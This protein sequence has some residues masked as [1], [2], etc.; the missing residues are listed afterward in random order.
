M[1]CVGMVTQGGAR[2][3]GLE[4]LEVL[5]A[6]GVTTSTTLTFIPGHDPLL[7]AEIACEAVCDPSSP[8]VPL[9]AGAGGL[10]VFAA[11]YQALRSGTVHLRPRVYEI[12][13]FVFE[14]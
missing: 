6:S 1:V 9:T 10:V 2:L 14:T 11:A 7:L 5:G 12:A 8:T 4:V 13:N 3:P